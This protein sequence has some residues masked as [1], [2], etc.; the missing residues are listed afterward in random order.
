MIQNLKYSV[1][2]DIS[3]EKFDACI[4][5]IN[6][7]QN[8]VVKAS[9]TFKNNTSGIKEFILWINKH[10]KEE[11]PLVITAEATGVYYELFAIT[12][13]EHGYNIS[14]VLPN[15]S[16]R[17]LQSKGYKSK[18]DKIDAKGL[19]EMGAEQN[20][21]KWE[22]FSKNIYVLRSLTRQNEDLQT[23]KTTITNRMEAN[24]SSGYKSEF[25]ENQLVNMLKS[26]NKH[27]KEVKD[28]IQKLIEGNEILKNKIP[29]ICKVKGLGILTVATIVAET[30]GF[31]LIQNQRQLVSY[32]GYDIIENQSGKRSGKTKISKKGNSHIRRALHMPALSV[33][34]Y[35]Q[36][37]FNHLYNRVF[38]RT[39][40]KMKGYVAVQR[41]LLILIYTL[42]KKDE[43]YDPNYLIRKDITFGDEESKFLFSLNSEGVDKKVGD[44][45][46]PTQD[47]LPYDVSPE[48]LFSLVQK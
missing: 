8:T 6:T 32:A 46:S 39:A 16:R 48:V 38:I 5:V 22:P 2:A 34:K 37:G 40:I 17:Y 3:K 35:K 44:Q 10:K 36:A 42:W 23:I 41:K 33:V 45:K 47:K 15:K 4:S 12:I 25:I 30:N 29:K 1:G 11:I 26:I 13:Y 14:V 24:K 21:T 28:Q 9:K 27:I 18:N 19:S 43:E 31:K 7:L 20:L